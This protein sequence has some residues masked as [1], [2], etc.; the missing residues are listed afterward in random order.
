MKVEIYKNQQEASQRAY[1]IIAN[2]LN[3]N[4]LNVMGLATGSTPLAL[5]TIL[6]NSDL[7][8]SK[9]SAANLDEYKG[10]EAS[11]EQSYA[12]FMSEHLFKHKPFLKT[13]IPN[14]MAADAAAEC[15]RYNEILKDHPI[16]IQILGIGSNAH[17]GFNEPG[18]AFTSQTHLVDLT[19][20]TIEANK[21]FFESVDDVPK[22]AFS[23]GIASIMS[24]KKI[25][26]M[27]FGSSKAEAIR[28]TVEGAVTENVPASILQN[29]SDVIILCDEEAAAQLKK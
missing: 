1:E 19:K 22:Q 6:V 24:A 15:N 18:T 13:Y 8:F 25:I 28:L 14:G 11:N 17:I 10:L 29:H 2:E 7:D 27:A 3:N 20:E 4:Q 21:R 12:Y 26:L 9:V 5:Y 23:M 16:D